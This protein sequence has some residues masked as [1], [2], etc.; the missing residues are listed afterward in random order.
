MPK[1]PGIKRGDE[2]PHAGDNPADYRYC[3]GWNDDCATKACERLKYRQ[4]EA[5]RKASEYRKF[6]GKPRGPN[7]GKRG[8]CWW[9]DQIIIDPKTG[10]ASKRR[11][12]HDGRDGERNCAHEFDLHTRNEVQLAFIIGRDGTKC[13]ACGEEKGSWVHKGHTSDPEKLRSWGPSWVR[14]YPPD[15]YV[16][17]FTQIGRTASLEVDHILCLALVVLTI[18]ERQRWRYWGPSNIQGLCASCHRVKTTEDVRLIKEARA[19]AG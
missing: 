14:Y 17:E 10:E 15:I 12:K 9:C 3:I 11:G 19:N 2:C 16:G 8:Y 18:Q 13:S 7:Y 1:V 4:Q 6:P 5:R